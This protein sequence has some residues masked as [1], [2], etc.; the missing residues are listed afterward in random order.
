MSFVSALVFVA[1]VRFYRDCPILSP[2]SH[3]VAIVRFC[4]HTKMSSQSYEVFLCGDHTHLLV[5]AFVNFALLDGTDF[6]CVLS[7]NA[8]FDLA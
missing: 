2:L 6:R 4:R 3:F 1:I 8:P 7:E 5:S